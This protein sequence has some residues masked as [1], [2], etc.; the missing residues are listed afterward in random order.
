MVLT[1]YLHDILSG[2]HDVPPRHTCLHP[3]RTSTTP[4]TA[5]TRVPRHTSTTPPNKYPRRTS[6]TGFFLHSTTPPNEYPRRTSTTGVFYVLHDN[7]PPV[8]TTYLHDRGVFCAP[9][10]PPPV[11]TTYLHDTGFFALHDTPPRHA[12][13][14]HDMLKSVSW[15]IG[16]PCRGALVP[17]RPSANSGHPVVEHTL[18]WGP[19]RGGVS[20]TKS[21]MSWKHVVGNLHSTTWG[22]GCRGEPRCFFH[23][24]PRHG[25]VFPTTWGVSWRH[26][27]ENIRFWDDIILS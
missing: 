5:L 26:V 3:R 14:L 21:S 23:C 8:P 10:H 13:V 19:C 17:C 6:T 4:L 27:V 22:G 20:W 16:L 12:R 25:H 24:C 1:T 2:T 18:S 7:P 9:R 15:G 11:P